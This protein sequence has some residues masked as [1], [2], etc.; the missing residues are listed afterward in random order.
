MEHLEYDP[1]FSFELG[2]KVEMQNLQNLVKAR[3]SHMTDMNKSF[4]YCHFP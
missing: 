4:L 1:E 2:Y 3:V